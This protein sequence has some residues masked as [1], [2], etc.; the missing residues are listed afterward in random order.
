MID[1]VLENARHETSHSHSVLFAL[2]IVEGGFDLD[3]PLDEHHVVVVADA[4]LPR[5]AQ[6]VGIGGDTWIEN[7][8]K[9]LVLAACVPVFPRANQ[10][11]WHIW[12][13]YLGGCNAHAFTLPKACGATQALLTEVDSIEHFFIKWLKTGDLLQTSLGKDLVSL[14][15]KMSH[16]MDGK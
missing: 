3:G 13:A 9:L 12:L 4:T 7:C 11:E 8:L 16:K 2:G 1:F 10:E 14:F 6:I 15:K 5:E